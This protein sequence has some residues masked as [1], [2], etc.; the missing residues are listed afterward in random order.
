MS[1]Q[2]PKIQ[3]T[4]RVKRKFDSAHK[5]NHY[6]GPCANVHGHTWHFEVYIAISKLM[7]NVEFGIDFKDIKK[8]IDELITD[9][10]DHKMLNECVPYFAS[11]NPTAENIAEY[12]LN[13]LYYVFKEKFNATVNRVDVWETENSCVTVTLQNT[14]LKE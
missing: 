10:L 4:L 13:T 2:V 7:D 11:K 8:T 12:I 1:Q 14:A 5:L 6:V 3:Q 9:K